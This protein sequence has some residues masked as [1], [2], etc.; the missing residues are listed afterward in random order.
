[1]YFTTWHPYTDQSAKESFNQVCDSVRAFCSIPA[2]VR[3]RFKLLAPAPA[4]AL[5]V[6][7]FVCLDQVGMLSQ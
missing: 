4:P 5:A 1:M 2:S 3:K 6:F 7:S